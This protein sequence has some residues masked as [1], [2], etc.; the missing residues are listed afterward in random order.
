MVYKVLMGYNGRVVCNKGH[1]SIMF[2]K[3][4]KKPE[5]PESGASEAPLSP[6]TPFRERLKARGAVRPVTTLAIQSGAESSS[7]PVNAGNDNM[8]QAVAPRLRTAPK[9]VPETG[10][11]TPK[12]DALQAQ[13]PPAETQV[14]KHTRTRTASTPSAPA[15]FLNPPQSPPMKRE[16]IAEK[17]AQRE[18]KKT[19]RPFIYGPP[20]GLAPGEPSSKFQ[21]IAAASIAA[22]GAAGLSVLAANY[23]LGD[24][25]PP[26]GPQIA[27]AGGAGGSGPV[28]PAAAGT[29]TSAAALMS[30]AAAVKTADASLDDAANG[31]NAHGNTATGLAS[32]GA[33]LKDAGERLTD[34]LGDMAE[35]GP[36]ASGPGES[37]Q[38]E[39]RAESEMTGHI[40]LL[41]L[42]EAAD[43]LPMGGPDTS[44][45]EGV[46]AIVAGDE[47]GGAAELTEASVTNADLPA[48]GEAG[49]SVSATDISRAADAIAARPSLKPAAPRR[50]ASLSVPGSVPGAASTK[51]VR[52]ALPRNS[53]DMDAAKV[54][55]LSGAITDSPRTVDAFMAQRI[56]RS[57]EAD[58][59]AGKLAAFK[60]AFLEQVAMAA[61]GETIN[62]AG[63]DGRAIRI[64]V[65]Q[66]RS[67]PHSMPTSRTITYATD[68]YAETLN[69]TSVVTP[70]KVNITCRDLSYSIAGSESGRFAACQTPQGEW[71]L[72]VAEPKI[73]VRPYYS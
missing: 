53:Y 59:D 1:V 35:A 34:N 58:I 42:E 28:L 15:P 69:F 48:A 6:A 31:S 33:A 41:S 18:Q 37:A 13:L 52:R 12:R 71:T 27:D 62:S 55:R 57:A 60:A 30:A 25:R 45:I 44:L 38:N 17:A 5:T 7:T 16:T 21:V 47:A 8:R 22:I 61:D 70:A 65:E 63:P 23:L 3:N 50:L 9:R 26:A 64:M 10:F 56:V 36:D 72:A 29:D 19:R 14:P 11:E 43:D 51:P 68:G 40:D 2:D 49:T 66:S 46:D 4:F 32:A 20:P 24:A 67:V 73:S 54:K 39:D